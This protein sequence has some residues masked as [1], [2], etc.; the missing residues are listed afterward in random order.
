VTPA[1]DGRTWQQHTLA[2][3]LHEQHASV[4]FSNTLVVQ[5]FL[6]ELVLLG[7]GHSH[8]EVLRS[9]GMKPVAGVRLTL[10]TRDMHTPYS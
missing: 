4:R 2:A 10:V 8:V 5:I 3:S 7:G 6:Q 1:A 9:W